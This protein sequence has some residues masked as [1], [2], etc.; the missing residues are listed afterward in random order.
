MLRVR[1]QNYDKEIRRE[2]CNNIHTQNLWPKKID[3]GG[4]GGID[5]ERV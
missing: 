5:G 3:S 4:G 2:K 1:C